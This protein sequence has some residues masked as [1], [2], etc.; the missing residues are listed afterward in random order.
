MEKSQ[1]IAAERR[2]CVSHIT[3][4]KIFFALCIYFLTVIL[5]IFSVTFAFLNYF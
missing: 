1:R 5:I 3:F 2:F 4:N